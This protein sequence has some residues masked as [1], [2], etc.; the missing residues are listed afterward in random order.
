[1]AVTGVRLPSRTSEEQLTLKSKEVKNILLGKSYPSSLE[2]E[3]LLNPKTEVW[4]SSFD[5][6][7]EKIKPK[8]HF[9][10]RSGK[11]T[12]NPLYDYLFDAYTFKEEFDPILEQPFA[13]L[14]SQI[15]LWNEEAYP[16]ESETIPFGL[17]PFGTYK[18]SARDIESYRSNY[19]QDRE[20]SFAD[21]SLPN[22]FKAFKD[23]Y[24]FLKS[25]GI[26]QLPEDSEATLRQLWILLFSYKQLFIS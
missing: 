16:L 20:I 19:L 24:S 6:R 17:T 22:E 25:F 21:F 1:M 14:T 3:I 13:D 4:D 23:V 8:N 26:S 11:Q 5:K 12:L 15:T 10:L 18:H 2:S 9:R 7:F